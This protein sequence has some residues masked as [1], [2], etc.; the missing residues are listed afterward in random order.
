PGI[1][2]EVSWLYD[3]GGVVFFKRPVLLLAVVIAALGLGG[4]IA[5]LLGGHDFFAP[6]GSSVLLGCVALVVAYYVATFIHESAHALTC[7]HF[8]RRVDQGGFMLFYL[9]PAFYVDVTDV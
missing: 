6:L 1:D 4:F 2:G 3:D 9:M 7:K 5:D 8:G